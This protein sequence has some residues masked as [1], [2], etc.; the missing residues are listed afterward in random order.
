M[1]KMTKLEIARKD[2]DLLNWI[3]L[4]IIFSVALGGVVHYLG[5]M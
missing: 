3:T 1:V 4:V 5:T 2:R